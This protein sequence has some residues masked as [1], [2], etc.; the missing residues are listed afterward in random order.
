VA[1]FDG[2]AGWASVISFPNFLLAH[3]I[4]TVGIE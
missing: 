2:G 1:G 4:P 3:L